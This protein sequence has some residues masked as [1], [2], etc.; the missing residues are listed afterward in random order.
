MKR[1][2]HTVLVIFTTLFLATWCFG[3]PE[4]AVDAQFTST[5]ADSNKFAMTVPPPISQ[6]FATESP[7]GETKQVI[8]NQKTG[9]II[10]GE[11][12]P[13]YTAAVQYNG[14]EIRISHNSSPNNPTISE[15]ENP[16]NNTIT[17]GKIVNVLLN[18]SVQPTEII[19]IFK[20]FVEEG[21]LHA[22][23]VLR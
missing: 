6:F 18:L 9:Q 1:S 21:S 12:V 8:I 14:M 17:A 15:R 11:S 16:N 13:I 19:E 10:Q 7:A 5:Q 23:L 20:I 2:F 3:M 22:K 4:P